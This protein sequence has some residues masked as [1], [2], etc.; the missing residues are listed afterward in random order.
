MTQNVYDNEVFFH[1][2]SVLRSNEW[3]ANNVEEQPNFYNML[4][5][6]R[7]KTVLDLGCGSGCDCMH[8]IEIGAKKVT[9]LDISRN[10]IELAV[11]ENPHRDITYLR[12]DMEQLDK[13]HGSFDVV[14]S[15]L[16]IHYIMNL[17]KLATDICNLLVPGGYFVFSQEHPVFTAPVDGPK[18]T[19]S[20][21][22]RVEG[23]LLDNYSSSGRRDVLW[24]EN[25][26][27]KYH[28]TFSDIINTLITVGF[29]IEE[30]R[31]PMIGERYFQHDPQ[32]T[33]TKHVPD[34]LMVR[35]KKVR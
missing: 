18:W 1:N 28:R 16:A 29:Q 21:G 9:G 27:I 5:N 3:S 13:L 22:G 33:R 2:Y 8:F 26:V 15:S 31:E 12:A 20:M 14:T 25:H 23:M 35:V 7:G 10:M 24:L 34:Y 6:L 4:P 11:A 32:Y 30:V 19:T 17:S